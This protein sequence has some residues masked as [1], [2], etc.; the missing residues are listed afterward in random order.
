MADKN[1]FKREARIRRA[2]RIR[3]KIK[4]TGERPR[5][6]VFKSLKHVYAQLVNDS[7]R[8]TI[9]GVSSHPGS[10]NAIGSKTA[11]A[12]VVGKAIAEKALSLGIKEVVFDRSGYRYHGKIKAL[13]EA[14]R[15]AGLKF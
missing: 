6:V 1:T 2:S 9:T 3:N 15:Q 7:E 14:A 10:A 12:K 13:A 8:K 11:K 5:L 4:G